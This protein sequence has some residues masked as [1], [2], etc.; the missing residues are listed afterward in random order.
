MP[1]RTTKSTTER[2][3]GYQ[4]QQERKSLLRRHTDGSL[5]WWCDRPMFKRDADNWDSRPLAA[6]H[7]IARA[8]GGTRAD[9]L[10]HWTCNA[11]RGDGS[12]DHQRPT[13][14]GRTVEP[15]TPGERLLMDW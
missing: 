5:C 2:G 8:L 11:Q 13:L 7:S 14:T 9:R 15:V 4:H 1:R 3:L 10:L 12:R 6:D